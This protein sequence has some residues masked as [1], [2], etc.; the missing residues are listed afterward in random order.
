MYITICTL[1]PDMF[2]GPF[3]QSIIKRAIQKGIVTIDYI[4]IRDFATD[5]HKSVDEHPFGG[6]AGMILR[7]DILDQAITHAKSLHTD[8][9][10][11]VILMDPQGVPFSQPIAETFAATP[12]THLIFVCGHYEGIDERIR[13]LVDMEISIGDYILTCGE[14]PAMVIVDSIV[15][16]LPGTLKKEEA[17]RKESFHPG[18]PVLEYPQYTKPRVYKRHTVPNILLSGNHK[19]I[20][21]WQRDES[22]KRTKKRRPDILT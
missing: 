7:V 18:N 15:R 12:D 9:P 3:D 21:T 8:I 2:H 20:E 4:N 11:T 10:A 14:L 22:I 16:L 17:T 1:F 5:K 13:D 6:G 19:D